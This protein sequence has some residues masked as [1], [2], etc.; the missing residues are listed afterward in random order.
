MVR[1]KSRLTPWF[2]ALLRSKLTPATR[3]RLWAETASARAHCAKE[4]ASS[5]RQRYASVPRGTGQ[6]RALE[7]L[8]LIHLLLSTE[9][10]IQYYPI[11]CRLVCRL[12]AR[13]LSLDTVHR[14][15]RA[16]WRCGDRRRR[17]RQ[18]ARAGR[19]RS[20]R[21]PLATS[22]AC[23]SSGWPFAPVCSAPR[24]FPA[25]HTCTASGPISRLTIVSTN[26][27]APRA[28]MWNGSRASE[29]GD[30][31][32]SYWMFQLWIMIN[33]WYEYLFTS[34]AFLLFS[35]SHIVRFCLS[36]L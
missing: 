25:A 28:A 2:R 32:L 9:A 7:P 36:F 4:S 14:L 13:H 10:S 20:R 35:N 33:I 18:S 34:H 21:A 30:R 8:W 23:V 11:V 6:S 1:D 29:A 3:L 31:E 12:S 22:G 15:Q 19:A 17:S 16:R 5:V 24:R 27:P 26:G